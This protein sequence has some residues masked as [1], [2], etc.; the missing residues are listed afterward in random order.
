MKYKLTLLFA[1]FAI[2]S[3]AQS[4]LQVLKKP[5]WNIISSSDSRYGTRLNLNDDNVAMIVNVPKADFAVVAIDNKLQ[6]KWLVTLDGFPMAMGKFKGNILVVAATDYSYSKSF[7]NTFIGY[8]IEEKTGKVITKKNLYN[9]TSDYMEEPQFFFANDGSYFKMTVRL[10]AMKKKS[11]VNSTLLP[12]VTYFSNLGTDKDF[13]TT[14]DYNLIDFDSQ[15]EQAQK[16]NPIMPLGE[17]WDA[18]CAEDG[19]LLILTRDS[20]LAQCNLAFYTSGKREPLKTIMVPVDFY[21]KT[22]GGNVQFASS[23]APLVYYFSLV[24]QNVN[25]DASL[26]V[27]KIDFRDNTTTI[28]KEIMDKAHTKELIK[29]FVV[30]NKKF[31]DI[32]FS[33][34]YLDVK[35]IKEYGSQVLVAVSPNYTVSYQRSSYNADE[36]VLLN[37]YDQKLKQQYHQFIP[38]YYGS[39]KGE[40]SQIAFSLKGDLL[41]MVANQK[42]GLGAVTTRY[43]EMDMKSG[44]ILKLVELP[45]DDIR[46]QYYADTEAMWWQNSS[47]TLPFVE[48]R[49]WFSD[50][51]DMQFLQLSY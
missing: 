18:Y 23:E 13:A 40:G 2:A 41:R 11:R 17:T 14:V 27:A 24:Y 34:A 8:L 7:T 35:S 21:K 45:K 22:R 30:V 4:Q 31:D 26:L 25:Q 6:Q 49:G 46:N 15:L 42:R 43:A 1:F 19:T 36:S 10:T 3:F 20:K 47:F 51:V 44:K 12:L 38:R 50:K 28:E 9:G 32:Y 33:S 16:T 29:S 48:R 5:Q 37:V 39:L